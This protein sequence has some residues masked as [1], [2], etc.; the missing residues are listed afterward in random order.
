VLTIPADSISEQLRLRQLQPASVLA[1]FVGGS[2]ARGWGHANS[3]LDIFVV[4]DRPWRSSTSAHNPVS[5]HPET[6]AT[7]TIHVESWRWEI[8]Y[9]QDTQVD[10]VLAKVSPDDFPGGSAWRTLTSTE[11]TFL[12]RLTRAVEVEGHDWLDRRQDA[13]RR[14]AFRAI[15][16]TDALLRADSHV[17]DA[18]GQLQSDDVDSAVLSARMAFG[19][20]IDALVASN[21]EL[22]Q[23]RKWRA[24]RMRT[25]TTPILSFD[26]YWEVETMQTF[27]P[28]AARRWVEEVAILCRRLSQEISI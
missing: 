11:S 23:E 24:R 10:Q 9:W 15:V 4:T 18:V 19:S 21:G 8:R 22:G 20:A 13:L 5:L 28:A 27:D 6:V 14:S 25:V 2:L 3:D 1:I 7:E 26:E 12:E 16:V 17:E